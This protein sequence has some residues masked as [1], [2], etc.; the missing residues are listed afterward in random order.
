VDPAAGRAKGAAAS[1][2]IRERFTWERTADAVE[3]R[4]R[5]LDERERQPRTKVRGSEPHKGRTPRV[6]LT[7]IVKNDDPY[8]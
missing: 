6:S 2:W 8:S 1:A 5:A 4:L 3:Q 7:M